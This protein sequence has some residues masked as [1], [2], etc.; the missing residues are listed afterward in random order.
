MKKCPYCC[1]EIQDGAIKCKH[2]GELLTGAGPGAPLP[3]PA[4]STRPLRRSRQERMLAGVCG[5]LAVHLGM[6]V[7][8]VRLLVALAILVSGVLPGIIVYVVVACILPEE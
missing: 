1:E 4:R 7:T 2:C 6:D 8:L 3:G 5:G